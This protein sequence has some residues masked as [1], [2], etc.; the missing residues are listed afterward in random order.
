MSLDT[1]ILCRAIIQQG[2]R[3]GKQC[4]WKKK[5]N[6]YCIYHQRNYF[7]ETLIKEGKILCGM[8]F[9]GC[10]NE[11]S[12]DD[13]DKSYKNCISCREK[14]L[15]KSFNCQYKDCTFKI[16]I[17]EEKYC[18]KHIRQT[19]YDNELIENIKY[20]DISRGCF[21]KI[22]EVKKC[23]DCKSKEKHEISTHIE[24]LR[25]KYD[26]TPIT[27]PISTLSS[28][29]E[30]IIISV[31][32]LW[33]S[34][35]KGAYNRELLFTITETDFER[36]A[37]LPC[38]YCGFYSKTRLNG[39][40]R[41][42]NN[43]GYIIDNCITC[44]KMCN[45]IKNSQHPNEFL[46]KID[47]IIN[48]SINKKEFDNKY[49]TKWSSYISKN[50]NNSYKNYISNIKLRNIEMLLTE[51]EYIKIIEGSCYL[52]GITN[53]IYH[54]N[55]I[56]RFNN[57]I[58]IYSIENSKT[59]CGH[60]NQM[61]GVYAY[62]DFI[63]KCIQINKYKCDRNIFNSVLK[64]DN[65][66]CRNEFYTAEDIFTF[67]TQGKYIQFLDWCKEKE[68][69]PEFI[70]EMNNICN[71]DK[72]SIKNKDSIISEIHDELEKERR[73][74]YS[75]KNA[76]ELNKKNMQCTTIYA[77]LVN[78][79]QNI[80]IN[81]YNKH[82]KKTMLFDEQ[83]ET[84]IKSLPSL[85]KEDG[86]KACQKFMYDE[87]NRRNAQLRRDATQKIIKYTNTI[88]T[89]TKELPIITES[90]IDNIII[91]PLKSNSIEEKIKEIQSSTGYKKKLSD[92]II[93]WKVKQIYDSINNDTENTY[94]DF[95]EK[96]NDISKIENWNTYWN[97]FISSV[98]GKSFIDAEK[99]IKD[100]I[101]HLR[102]IRHNI[103]CYEKN[104]KIID[105]EDRQQWPSISIVRAFMDGKIEVFKKYTEEQ[106]GDDPDNPTW[107]KS[108]NKFIKNLE[109]NKDNKDK[110]K[111]ICT[112]FLS[113]QRIKR[114]RH[115][116]SI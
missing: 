63:D 113:A 17:K 8:F 22:I 102:T 19:L 110:L 7:Y 103:L 61:K 100:F 115:S 6:G 45:I 46:D 73:R 47:C 84:L 24:L 2:E 44:C 41:I 96:N 16:K 10:N 77:Y 18:K 57:S 97:E 85:T 52:C 59:C 13:I 25:E 60:C 20:C 72:L 33:R 67:M 55:G 66:K 95:C 105:R 101:E 58:R 75:H 1:T 39:I 56:D 30:E 28:K 68:K 9:R 15:G 14:K 99:T 5:E 40:D 94:R 23:S 116:K 12:T 90:K 65:T 37:I 26:V 80:F 21:N 81:W 89:Q 112:K 87:K 104:S 51:E 43:K 83:F 92:E 79:K 88:S 76:D 109:D 93:Q 82:Y 71:S 3:A 50:S 53:S 48:Y 70:S 32:E 35:Q 74:Q 106:S 78:G 36:L 27:T 91:N 29:Q 108:W 4:Q 62:S 114:Y 64:Y 31:S 34:I 49:S 111:D 107:Q 11:L 38:Y 86:I 69:T 98:K 42:D 54:Q